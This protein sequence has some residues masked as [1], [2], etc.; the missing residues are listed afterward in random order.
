MAARSVGCSAASSTFFCSA[1]TWFEASSC[2]CASACA[3]SMASRRCCSTSICPRSAGELV[4]RLLQRLRALRLL[5]GELLPLLGGGVD[6]LLQL[7]AQRGDVLPHLLAFLRRRHAP[8]GSEQEEKAKSTAKSQRARRLAFCKN[9]TS[10]PSRLRGGSCSC[11]WS[12]HH[13]SGASSTR[14]LRAQAAS[15]WP[16]SAD[17]SFP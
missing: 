7:R 10:R 3:F 14:R 2:F 13:C 11:S 15:S 8:A 1:A 12:L 5:G 6:F 16:G 9:E 17:R 4:E